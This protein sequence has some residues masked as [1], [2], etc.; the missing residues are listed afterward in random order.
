[1]MKSWGGLVAGAAL[2]AVASAMLAP[3]RAM[4]WDGNPSGGVG[5][6]ELDVWGNFNVTLTGEAGRLMCSGA[7]NNGPENEWY[8]RHAVAYTDRGTADGLKRTYASL[9]AAQL[10]GKTVT[11]YTTNLTINYT[12]ANGQARQR[13]ECIIGAMDVW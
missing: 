7:A 3:S 11:L 5:A 2:F 9:L 12:D 10:S 13:T 6:L 4:A 1:M 8:N